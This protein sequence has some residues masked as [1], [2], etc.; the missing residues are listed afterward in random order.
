MCYNNT[1]DP[2]EC[3][4]RVN[5]SA[6]LDCTVTGNPQPTV[7]ASTDSGNA[8]ALV[9]DSISF[10]VVAYED[11]GNYTCIAS[12][13]IGSNTTKTFTVQVAGQFQA[14]EVC[15]DVW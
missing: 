6:T 8:A 9:N 13:G 15:L 1:S 4:V 14:Y 7:T 2:I 10:N 3:A 12:N 11:A 5:S